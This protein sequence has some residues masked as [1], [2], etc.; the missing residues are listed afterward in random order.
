MGST[1]ER[2][3]ELVLHDEIGLV[4]VVSAAT[5]P[6]HIVEGLGELLAEPL[7]LGLHPLA[8]FAQAGLTGAAAIGRLAKVCDLALVRL[9]QL[10]H[11]FGV[12][13]GHDL[14][15]DLLDDLGLGGTRGARLGLLHQLLELGVLGQE[16][17]DRTGGRDLRVQF[18]NRLRQTLGLLGAL[19]CLLLGSLQRLAGILGI[20]LFGS[21]LLAERLHLL[22][23]FCQFVGLLGLLRRLCL[24]L[25]HGRGSCRLRGC[26]RLGLRLPSGR[27]TARREPQIAHYEEGNSKNQFQTLHDQPNCCREGAAAPSPHSPSK[28][29]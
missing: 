11:R 13:Q 21:H 15:D 28:R 10:R 26:L 22:A 24:S 16:L 25:R 17:V 18:A 27:V 4:V 8:L 6:V 12:A 5:L 14:L 29:G 23:R 1:V 20:V 2:R 3:L 9:L 7:E 19:V